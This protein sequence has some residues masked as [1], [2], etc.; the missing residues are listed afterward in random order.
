[1]LPTRLVT[2][3]HPPLAHP[4]HPGHPLPG[5]QFPIH[6]RALPQHL[7]FWFTVNISTHYPFFFLHPP[8][9]PFPKPLPRTKYKNQKTKKEQEETE[10]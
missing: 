7:G 10:S 4:I 2:N 1:M 8:L 9:S 6:A 5:L 3:L